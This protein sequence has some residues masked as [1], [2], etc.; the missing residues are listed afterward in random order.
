M[1]EV[2]R[3]GVLVVS[4]CYDLR[5]LLWSINLNDQGEGF[6]FVFFFYILQ[7][8]VYPKNKNCAFDFFNLFK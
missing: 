2:V 5:L 6:F 3:V 8:V 7:S 4:G 1:S